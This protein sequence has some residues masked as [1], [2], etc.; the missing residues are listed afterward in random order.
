MKR[1]VNVGIVCCP[2][3]CGFLCDTYKKMR[4]H[5]KKEHTKTKKKRAKK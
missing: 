2:Y 3:E 5:L 1:N 4:A